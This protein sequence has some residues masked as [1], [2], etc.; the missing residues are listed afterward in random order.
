MDQ[1]VDLIK[2]ITPL[3]NSY[4]QNKGK[5]KGKDALLIMWDIGDLLKIFIEKHK[6]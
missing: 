5:I 6:V 3:Y 2:A 1:K 4:K